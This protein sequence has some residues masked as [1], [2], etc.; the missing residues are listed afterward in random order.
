MF[1]VEE[2]H[3]CDPLCSSE[4]CWGP[5]PDQCVSCKNYERRNMCYNNATSCQG[6]YRTLFIYLFIYF[7]MHHH[8]SYIWCNWLWKKNI[9]IIIIIKCVCVWCVC[10]CVCVCVV[11]VCGVCVCVLALCYIVGTKCPHKDS[12][13]WNIWHC[14]D[15]P[16]VPTREKKYKKYKL[17]LSESVTMQSD[18]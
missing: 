13:T 5:G 18:K 17:C 7:Y 2:G 1:V 12:K 14:G 6:Q 3:V 10:V 16:V 8:C 9:K 15:W 11:C 4:G